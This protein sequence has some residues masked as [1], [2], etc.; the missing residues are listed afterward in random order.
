VRIAVGT[1]IN[2]RADVV[3][4]GLS[5]A[6]QSALYWPRGGPPVTLRGLSAGGNDAASD[7]NNRG[8]IVGFSEP[9]A[10][11]GY[12]ATVWSRI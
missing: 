4:F 7:V 3:G 1:G 10:G 12:H 6:R 5:E 2:D 11:L 8:Q 9:V